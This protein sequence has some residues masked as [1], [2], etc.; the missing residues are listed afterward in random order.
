MNRVLIA[1]C[2]L[3]MTISIVAQPPTNNSGINQNNVNSI[4]QSNASQLQS[5]GISTTQAE[6]MAN[7]YLANQKNNITAL[8]GD[9]T[10]PVIVKPVVIDTSINFYDTLK[11]RNNRI[12]SNRYAMDVFLNQ[13]INVFNKNTD[14][15]APE[16]YIIG[17]GDKINVAIWGYASYSSSLTVDETGAIFP[18][19]T[20]KIYLRGLT[21]KDAK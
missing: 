13:D 14:V 15:Q 20:G 4:I 3:M 10:K 8:P 12:R 6:Q 2:F 9:T 21:L 17:T 1:L 18:S 19:Q 7:Q 11:D 5:I 16:N